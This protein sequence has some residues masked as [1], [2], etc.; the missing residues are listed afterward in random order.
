MRPVRARPVQARSSAMRKAWNGQADAHRIRVA[1][2]RIPRCRSTT[3]VRCSAAT[4]ALAP[5]AP[6]NRPLCQPAAARAPA[7]EPLSRRR[8]RA[9]WLARLPWEVGA[10]EGPCRMC[11]GTCW[12]SS[13]PGAALFPATTRGRSSRRPACAPFLAGAALPSR[14]T[15][16]CGLAAAT[17]LGIAWSSKRCTGIPAPVVSLVQPQPPAAG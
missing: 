14:Q 3:E 2:R 7:P 17:M 4:D 10:S 13:A 9:Q 1:A 6:H 8:L 15:R 5:R 16:T 12:G 11:T